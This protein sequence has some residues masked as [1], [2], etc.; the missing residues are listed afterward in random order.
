MGLEPAQADLRSTQR[1]VMRRRG[2]CGHP[3]FSY[4]AMTVVEEGFTRS[5][6]IH[7]TKD[8]AMRHQAEGFFN[9]FVEQG[10]QFGKA[11]IEGVRRTFDWNRILVTNL[12][13]QLNAPFASSSRTQRNAI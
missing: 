12:K 6:P 7:A 10:C 11:S 1:L 2:G 9:K 8:V 4:Q 5:Q 3:L 13:C